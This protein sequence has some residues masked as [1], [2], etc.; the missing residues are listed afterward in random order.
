MKYKTF[1]SLARAGAVLGAVGLV[2]AGV[3]T[4][5]GGEP[6]PVA[7][8]TPP[9]S[10]GGVPRPTPARPPVARSAPPEVVAPPL[11][12]PLPARTAPAGGQVF[13]DFDAPVLGLA[14]RALSSDKVKDAY[15]GAVKVNL[16]Q[17]AGFTQV[18]RLKVD[19]DRDDK[20]DEKWTFDRTGGV[21]RVTRQVAPAD[22]ESYTVEYQAGDG[23]WL[24]RAR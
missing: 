20:W 21:V 3:Y 10:V 2:A 7:A 18:N 24:P 8:T 16:Y 12:L 11:N 22:D 9:V 13:R 17:D 4:C 6:A 1:I 5:S 14:A 15:P 23:V 19:L